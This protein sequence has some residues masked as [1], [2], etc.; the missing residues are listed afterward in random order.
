MKWPACSSSPLRAR[1]SLPIRPLAWAA[2][3][4]AR[5][6]CGCASAPCG[7]SRLVVSVSASGALT[8]GHS[9]TRPGSSLRLGR[10]SMTWPAS[11]TPC[12]ASIFT[13]HP[14]DRVEHGRRR[15]EG[16]I[17]VDRHEI[18]LGD[19]AL[20]GEPFAHLLE[21]ARIGALEA[22]DRLLG[23]ADGEHRAA[24][25]DRALARRRIPRSAGGS[26]PT[27][28]GW[29]PAPRRPARGRCR[30]RACRAPRPR[31]PRSPAGAAW[32][33]SGRRSRAP[34]AVAWRGNSG[35]RCRGRAAAAPW[36]ARPAPRR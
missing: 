20:F 8:S 13:E 11:T 6:S 36:C 7:P 16:D 4:W 23:V 32:P 27:G 14:I 31:W 1:C 19:A 12:A 2:I 25:L 5:R 9:S 30:R 34:R 17:E 26:P 22:E 3:R 24:A 21:L 29:C 33:R 18:L 28:R 10:C 15:A 35:R